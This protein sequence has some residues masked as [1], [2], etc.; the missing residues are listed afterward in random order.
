MRITEK[1]KTLL[2]FEKAIKFFPNN[3]D[4]KIQYCTYLETFKI[5]KAYQIYQKILPEL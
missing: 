3:I 5:K 2:A 4:L 1:K